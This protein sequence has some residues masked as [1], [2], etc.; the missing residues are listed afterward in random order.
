VVIYLPDPYG[1]Y[2]MQLKKYLIILEERLDGPSLNIGSP[3]QKI[4]ETEL[5][6]GSPW[7]KI[8]TWEHPSTLVID[9]KVRDRPTL[10]KVHSRGED[11]SLT[12]CTLIEINTQK[13]NRPEAVEEAVVTYIKL[14]TLLVQKKARIYNDWDNITGG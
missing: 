8:Y 3:W 1:S 14:M 11:Q 12:G 6:P 2:W 4:R 5:P 9:M 10:I 13:T 7:T